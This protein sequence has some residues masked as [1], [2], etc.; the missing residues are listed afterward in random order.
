MAARPGSF[1]P[2]AALLLAYY[3]GWELLFRGVLL[4]GLRERLGDGPANALQTALEMLWALSASAER[5][6][7]PGSIAACA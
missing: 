2:H 1:A 7:T 4:L 6:F 5:N 3:V